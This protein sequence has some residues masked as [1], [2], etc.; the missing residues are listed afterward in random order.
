MSSV[1]KRDGF[2][3]I[4]DPELSSE[5]MTRSTSFGSVSVVNCQDDCR[6]TFCIVDSETL[7]GWRFFSLIDICRL[8]R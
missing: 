4:K 5:K 1:Y 2:H 3:S 7:F 8:L 6:S